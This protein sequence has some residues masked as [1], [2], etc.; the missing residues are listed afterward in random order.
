MPLHRLKP[1]L[2]LIA[3]LAAVSSSSSQIFS[4]QDYTSND[5]L[6]ANGIRPLFQDS[7]GYLS[8]DG[9]RTRIRRIYEKLHVHTRSEAVAK[10][11]SQRIFASVMRLKPPNGW[12]KLGSH[13]WFSPF[14]AV[15][16]SLPAGN[17]GLYITLLVSF[18]TVLPKLPVFLMKCLPHVYGVGAYTL[19]CLTWATTSLA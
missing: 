15:L 5:G 12:F 9:V 16:F 3:L 19:Q 4:F 6:L 14:V 13:T 17:K 7:R 18:L 8:I 11:L 2:T 1:A 10:G